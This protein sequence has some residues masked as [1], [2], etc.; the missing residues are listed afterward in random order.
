G[1]SNGETWEWNGT[2]WTQRAVSGPSPR[3]H[4]AMAY[5][6]GRGV[7]V[8]FGGSDGTS[9]GETWEWNGSAWTQRAAPGPS[10]RYGHAMVHDAARRVMVL[11]GGDSGGVANGETWGLGVPCAA[12]FNTD[13]T[14]TVQDIF[15]FLNAWFARD[16]RANFNGS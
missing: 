10:A 16:Q 2:A 13:G 5:D 9:S 7:T 15:D 12:D 11:F 8:L 3:G 14:V 1:A 6:I 4:H